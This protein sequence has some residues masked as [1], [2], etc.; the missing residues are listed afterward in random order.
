MIYQ[1]TTYDPTTGSLISNVST[2][3]LDQVTS[4][5]AGQSYVEGWWNGDEYH[6]VNGVITPKPPPAPAERTQEEQATQIRRQRTVLLSLVDQIN[7]TWYASLTQEQQQEL[8]VYRQA[9]LDVPQ[10]S[11]FPSTVVWP[12]KPTWL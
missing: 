5:L 10:Q 7:P 8:S 11:G 3:S 9:L 6:V 2:D 12:T 1:Y 4:L